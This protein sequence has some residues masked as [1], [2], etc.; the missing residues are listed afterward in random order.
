MMRRNW[1][2]AISGGLL[3]A[4]GCVSAPKTKHEQD[5]DEV[6]VLIKLHEKNPHLPETGRYFPE[7]HSLNGHFTLIAGVWVDDRYYYEAVGIPMGKAPAGSDVR[8]RM[9][10]IPESVLGDCI[11]CRRSWKWVASHSTMYI[12][13][14]HNPDGSYVGGRGY[15]PMCKACWEKSSI[16]ERV[17]YYRAAW[18]EFRPADNSNPEWVA[19]EK[20]IREGK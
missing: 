16:E 19:L 18:T 11:R 20:A 8:D 7:N 10:G 13:T 17:Q 6:R 15:G 14:V 2:T 12:E 9:P 5:L 1:L 3:A 4:A